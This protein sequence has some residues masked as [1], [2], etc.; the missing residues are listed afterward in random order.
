MLSADQ[1]CHTL[2]GF[3]PFFPYGGYGPPQP[4]LQQAL[5][6]Q[7]AAATAAMF[8]GRQPGAQDFSSGPPER[9]YGP[10][11]MD[12]A[13]AMCSMQYVQAMAANA[14]MMGF[15]VAFRAAFLGGMCDIEPPGWI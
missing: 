1:G 15:Q 5:M 2:Q 12:P 11:G 7:Q 4:A 14:A 9:M 6:Q 8:A 10:P 13:A 3:N